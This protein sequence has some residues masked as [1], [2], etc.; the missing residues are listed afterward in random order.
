MPAPHFV[1]DAFGGVPI[2]GKLFADVLDIVGPVEQQEQAPFDVGEQVM[3]PPRLQAAQTMDTP[4]RA[5]ILDGEPRFVVG[6][7][8][9]AAPFLVEEGDLVLIER[10][11]AASRNTSGV[12]LPHSRMRRF[13]GRCKVA[14]YETLLSGMMVY[15]S[16]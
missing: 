8:S 15:Y 4:R 3:L 2:E 13:P 9:L 12:R 11:T 7:A 6:T 16:V 14:E 1:G 10:V 5:D